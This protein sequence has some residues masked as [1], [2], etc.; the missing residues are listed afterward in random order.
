MLNV[1]NAPVIAKI[2]LN[3]QAEKIT[4]FVDNFSR[5]VHIEHNFDFHQGEERTIL[6]FAKGLELIEEANKAGA[7]LAG[8][9]GLIRS[10]QNGDLKLID[11][12]YIIAHNNIL[13]ELVQVRG[14]MK[15]KFPNPKMGTLGNNITEMVEKFLNGITYKVTKDEN[16][17]D[18]ACTEIQIGTLDMPTEHLESNLRNLLLDIDTMRPKRDG[19]FITVANIF[20][21][22][23][24]E[25]LKIDP[26]VYVPAEREV[27]TTKKGG[28]R[29]EIE[30]EIEEDEEAKK[31]EASN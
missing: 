2:E 18:Y 6:V 19:K 31:A 15:K 7:T 10:I 9:G 26:F 14:L 4:R 12:Q 28:I 3:M 29:E 5:M 21:S 20:C 17:K 30:E 11:F 13:P 8:E 1:P 16:Q 25:S 27:T 23:S 22:P 24:K